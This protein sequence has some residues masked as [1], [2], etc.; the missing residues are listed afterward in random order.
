MRLYWRVVR[1]SGRL[2]MSRTAYVFTVPD[3]RLREMD[4]ATGPCVPTGGRKRPLRGPVMQDHGEGPQ[5]TAAFY[6]VLTGRPSDEAMT[7]LETKGPGALYAFTNAYVDALVDEQGHLEALAN[8]DE[9][10]GDTKNFRSSLIDWKNFLWLG[11]LRGSGQKTS[12]GRTAA[13]AWELPPTL[14][15]RGNECSRGTA[16]PLR[17]TTS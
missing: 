12:W 9:A 1:A 7:L 6:T 2:D 14:P 4:V 8:E 15:R 10:N 16:R 3:K 5:Q 13:S 17:R 11:S